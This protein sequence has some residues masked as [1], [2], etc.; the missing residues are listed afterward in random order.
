MSRTSYAQLT[1]SIAWCASAIVCM[2][3]RESGR[4][5]ERYLHQRTPRCE[6]LAATSFVVV[7]AGHCP[8]AACQRRSQPTALLYLC[9]VQ[10]S[11]W[12]SYGIA[13]ARGLKA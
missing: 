11:A 4:P 13:G 6:L 12:S 3:L 7:G 5:G 1:L 9:A 10:R 2:A 8:M